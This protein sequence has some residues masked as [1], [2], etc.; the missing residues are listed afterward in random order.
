M[1]INY[2]SALVM[3]PWANGL[4]PNPVSLNLCVVKIP[5]KTFRLQCYDWLSRLQFHNLDWLV[6]Q[7]QSS[8]HL[9]YELSLAED[10]A[11]L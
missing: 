7:I 10:N 11:L 9:Y 2:F 4:Y 8:S 5:L 3:T 1:R 6:S